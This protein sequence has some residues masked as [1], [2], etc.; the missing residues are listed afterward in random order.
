MRYRP[1]WLGK[2]FVDHPVLEAVGVSKRFANG[3]HALSEINLT[4]AQGETV[5]LIGESG[6]GK[7]TL[8]R[9]FN[10]LEEPTSGEILI[11]GRPARQEDPISLRRHIGYVQQDGG[12][13]PHWTVGRNV[14]LVPKLLGWNPD[15]YQPLAD[16]LLELVSL[17]P[18]QYRSRYPRELSGG[19]RQRVAVA[20]ALVADPDLVLLDEPFGALDALT[21][22]ELQNQFLHLK[23]QLGKTMVLVT[24]DLNEALRLGDRIA[25][26]RQGR[27]LQVGT[28][29]ELLRHPT[30]EY[31]QMLLKYRAGNPESDA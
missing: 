24:H 8:L 27:L 20:R 10:R 17:N 3:V 21:R 5:V 9:L 15:R 1:P 28:P 2:G 7:T 19:Q 29:D 30:D 6:S 18:D 31:V 4:V 23:R 14:A 25:V 22:I 16:R 26:L 11:Q 12:L 13:L